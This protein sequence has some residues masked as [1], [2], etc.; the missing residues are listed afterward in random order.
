MDILEAN[1]TSPTDKED[2]ETYRQRIYKESRTND[3][4]NRE[5]FLDLAYEYLVLDK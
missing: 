2:I 1:T 3:F 4:I 5:Q